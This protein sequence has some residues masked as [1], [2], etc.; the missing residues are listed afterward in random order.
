M[1]I[2]TEE[3]LNG[4]FTFLAV[5]CKFRVTNNVSITTASL[6]YPS[7]CDAIIAAVK[8]LVKHGGIEYIGIPSLLLRL[9]RSEGFASEKQ[10][11][12]VKTKNE[13]VVNDVRKF[14]WSKYFAEECAQYSKHALAKIHNKND[15]KPELL[16]LTKAIQNLKSFLLTR[17]K[18]NYRPFGISHKKRSISYIIKRILLDS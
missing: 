5:N 12:G 4:N 16:P 11:L 13:G 14:F 9:G 17:N 15:Q 3:I 6:T 2:F 18:Q 1:V 8:S 10:T 7:D